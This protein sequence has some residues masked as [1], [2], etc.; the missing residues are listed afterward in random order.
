[1][2]KILFIGLPL[3]LSIALYGC[4]ATDDPSENTDGMPE[5]TDD[6]K[7]QENDQDSNS[8]SSDGLETSD[9]EMVVNTGSTET[10]TRE[11][12]GMD[13][14]V[15][16]VNYDIEP[17]GISYQLD[18]LFGAPDT[19]DNQVIYTTENENHKI[20]FEVI[21]QTD[22]ETAAS[23]L[24]K[25]FEKEEYEDEGE[26]ES[27][28]ADENELEGKMQN[29]AYP[30]KGFY[31]YKIDEHVLVITYDYPV[32][33]GDGMVPLLTDLRKSLSKQ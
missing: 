24:Q 28:P 7:V 10:V 27:T 15:E 19:K 29:Y 3:I 1:M 6:E 14:E 9:A 11:I 22:V 21:E 23:N 26:L 5:E 18:K 4:S 16:V 30:M 17:Y 31:V 25:E 33:G 2:R 32:E 8:N 12:E 20:T 13:D